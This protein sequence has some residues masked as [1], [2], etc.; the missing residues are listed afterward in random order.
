MEKAAIEH[1][2][3]IERP[4]GIPAGRWEFFLHEY[5]DLR[6][7][8]EY[9]IDIRVYQ[10]YPFLQHFCDKSNEDSWVKHRMAQQ[11][12]MRSETYQSS[13]LNHRIIIPSTDTLFRQ[14]WSR[15]LR[16][17]PYMEDAEEELD[18]NANEKE[19]HVMDEQRSSDSPDNQ[20]ETT[21]RTTASGSR[22]PQTNSRAPPPPLRATPSISN[23]SAST[24]RS[25]T[26]QTR[27]TNPENQRA[28]RIAVIHEKLEDSSS[29]KVL[30]SS[31]KSKA[32]TVSERKGKQRQ[33]TLHP[34][35]PPTTKA[36]RKSTFLR[37][38]SWSPESSTVAQKP[39][40]KKTTKVPTKRKAVL[41]LRVIPERDPS[42]SPGLPLPRSRSPHAGSPGTTVITS[43]DAP[44]AG[45]ADST[46]STVSNDSASRIV[47]ATKA[48]VVVPAKR[49]FVAPAKPTIQC[50]RC[51]TGNYQSAE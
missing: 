37:Q 27:S 8:Y 20:P 25:P 33:P 40:Q 35:V 39:V 2:K 21:V 41:R 18:P 26:S 13:K 46:D 51:A 50:P 12:L 42:L 6:S 24:M 5:M 34:N 7:D 3:C 28:D 43:S 14:N 30:G 36:P 23:D 1:S 16:R 31:T 15:L 32:A 17:H 44:D 49:T 48:T 29:W 10:R 11:Y 19:K 38:G 9:F 4:S 45:A 47:S 22:A